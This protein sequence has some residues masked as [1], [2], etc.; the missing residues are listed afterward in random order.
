MLQSKPIHF[1]NQLDSLHNTQHYLQMKVDSLNKIVNET[2]IGTGF[3]SDVISQ[4]LYMF[5]TIVVVAGL[6]SWSFVA[7]VLALHKRTI[8]N[9]V[10]NILDTEIKKMISKFDDLENSTNYTSYNLQ[11]ALYIIMRNNDSHVNAFDYALDALLDL[12][13]LKE[14][15]NDMFKNWFSVMNTHLDNIGVANKD[16]I[17]KR[18]A[19]SDNLDEIKKVI[20]KEFITNLNTVKA[21]F[22]SKA[23][24]EDAP[25][26]DLAEGNAQSPPTNSNKQSF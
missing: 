8:Q 3:F 2:R 26:E 4:D 21:K 9:N 11:R 14:E 20:P 1:Q 12:L 13:K 17:E 5:S 10:T 6:I 19:M 25:P 18:E 15:D 7:G 24:T 23:F 16:L 22:Y